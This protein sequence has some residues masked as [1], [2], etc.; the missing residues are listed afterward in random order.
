MNKIGIFIGTRPEL[1]KCLPLINSSDIYVPIFVQQHTDIMNVPT[2]KEHYIIPIVEYGQNRLN[3]IMISIINSPIIDKSW[4]AILVQGDTAVAFAAAITAF[5]K[6]IKIIHLEA[7]LR[8]H[9][10]E[11]PWP[12]EGYRKMIDS[13]ANIALCPSN[14][15]A[16]NLIDEKFTGEI[17]IVGNTSIDAISNYNLNSNIGNTI[18]IT[19][20]RRENWDKI[21]NFFEVI[22]ELA[23]IYTDYNF[24][25]PI[26]PNPE[27]M[28]LQTIFNRVKV[29]NPLP[30]SDMCKL[31]SECN[32]IISDSGG[33]Q[34]EASFLGKKVFCCR[35]VTERTELIDKYIIYT[36][37]PECLKE[38]FTPQKELLPKSIVYGEGKS[39]LKINEYLTNI[40]CQI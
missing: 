14:Q 11:N 37:T 20:H 17:Q 16:Q 1:I 25:I 15:S 34:E 32:C 23:N 18:V 7:G 39:Y 38:L 36:P 29:I 24:V 28:K 30:H 4:K 19:L 33:I 8:T 35:K 22:E 21:K 2:N 31:L 5:N 27:I 10:L 26:H 3:N 6:K 13:I 9:D 40:L 12:E